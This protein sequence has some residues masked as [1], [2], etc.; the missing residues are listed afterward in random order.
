[1]CASQCLSVQ[2]MNPVYSKYPPSKTEVHAATQ[3]IERTTMAA[4]EVTILKKERHSRAE[5]PTIKEA[6]K[7]SIIKTTRDHTMA[8]EATV[9]A[10]GTTDRNEEQRTK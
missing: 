5:T 1:M 3:E 10:A 8:V 6:T 2:E 7:I 9:T 4:T